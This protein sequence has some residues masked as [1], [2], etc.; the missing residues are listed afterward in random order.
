MD[1]NNRNVFPISE[2]FPDLLERVQLGSPPYTLV[3]MPRPHKRV[4]N[5]I[6]YLLEFGHLRINLV[7]A[8]C[9]GQEF[10]F[11]V[12]NVVYGVYGVLNITTHV[13]QVLL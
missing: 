4:K 6:N 5:L 7:R 13:S 11:I 12:N 3:F 10:A 2:R 8:T 1:I 9:A